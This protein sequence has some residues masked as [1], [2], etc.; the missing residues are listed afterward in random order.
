VREEERVG[1]RT[2]LDVLN[3]E[4]EFLNSQVNLVTTQ[5]NHVVSNYAL[6]AAIGRLDALSLGVTDTIYDP[7]EHYLEVRRKPWGTSITRGEGRWDAVVEPAP[8]EAPV[9]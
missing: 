8:E 9:K 2:L 6:L 7:E 4:L 3:A 5:R 1:Q